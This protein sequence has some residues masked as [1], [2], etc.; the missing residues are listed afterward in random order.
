MPKR[1]LLHRATR[2]G[3]RGGHDGPGRAG[4]LPGLDGQA[5]A[6]RG[7]L[8]GE[9]AG[10]ENDAVDAAE[11]LGVP[12]DEEVDRAPVEEPVAPPS[13]PVVENDDERRKPVTRFEEP[14]PEPASAAQPDLCPACESAESRTLFQGSDRLYR[15]TERVF[16]VVECTGCRLIRLSPFPTPL[17]LRDYYPDTYWYVPEHDTVSRLEE[18]YRRFVLS[19]HVR[20][21]MGA[22]K[23][24]SV[25]APVLD[26]GCGGGLFLRMLAERGRRVVGLD[27]SL[28][29]AT[30]AWRINGVPALCGSLTQAPLPPG[31]C[32]AVTM[33]HV[34]EHLYDPAAYLQAAHRLLRP[35]G[36]LVIQVPNAGCWQMTLLGEHWAGIDIPRHLFNFRLRDLELLLDSC[37]FE[38][39]RTK[40]F[41][42]RDNPAGLATSLA[43][44]LDPMARRIRRIPETAQTKLFKDLVYLGLVTAALPFTMLEAAC[45]AGST[46]MIE[47]A[48]KVTP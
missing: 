12:A 30:A 14:V 11:A 22:L 33:F 46:I 15:T 47:A 37:G 17:E 41:S 10:T 44:G 16:K 8:F 42:L 24:C 29:A 39:A 1:R 6:G 21:V 40:F 35:D 32:A 36:R 25:D 5:E 19:D 23:H 4:P 2:R 38:I 26:V 28:Q 43:P 48:R 31:S 18:I 3:N 13:R 7:D 34:L 27:F 20:F 45:R 9:L